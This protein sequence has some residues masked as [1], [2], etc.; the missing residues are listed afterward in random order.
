MERVNIPAVLTPPQRNGVSSVTDDFHPD[1]MS[2]PRS[3]PNRGYQ[4]KSAAGIIGVGILVM[5]MSIVF[6]SAGAPGFFV[7]FPVLMGIVFIVAGLAANDREKR[8]AEEERVRA[9]EERDRF[10][11]EIAQSVKE[12]MKGTIKVRC[13]YCGALSDENEE[14]CE[15][16]GA[17]L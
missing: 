2:D 9:E 11:E 12:T 5:F 10:K 3:R 6:A 17:P 14:K 4:P 16:C 15:S 1:F 8:L 13:R 7:A